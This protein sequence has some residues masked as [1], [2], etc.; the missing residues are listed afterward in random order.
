M[1]IDEEMRQLG[2]ELAK[3]P[4]DPIISIDEAIDIFA[5]HL[6][7]IHTTP[8]TKWRSALNLGFEAL[9]W[10]KWRRKNYRQPP[11]LPLPGETEE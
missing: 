1:T 3:E 9:K 4:P 7:A 6:E 8:G 5:Y 11:I 10:I 2:R